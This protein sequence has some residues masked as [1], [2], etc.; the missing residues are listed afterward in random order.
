MEIKHKLISNN[1]HIYLYGELDECSSHKTRKVLDDLIDDNR[2]AISIT[3]NLSGLSFMD[4]TGIGMFLGRYKKIKNY[5]IPVFITGTNSVIDK[6]LEI[7][8]IY[9]IIPKK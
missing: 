4:S 6:I 7:S 8:G 3:F 2:F 9:T 1:L 5:K